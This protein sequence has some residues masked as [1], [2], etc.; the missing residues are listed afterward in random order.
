[1][2]PSWL[3]HLVHPFRGGGERISIAF[4]IQTTEVKNP[5]PAG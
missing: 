2:F 1:V 3:N 4:N 5:A